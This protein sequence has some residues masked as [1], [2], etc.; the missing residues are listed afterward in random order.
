MGYNES[1]ILNSEITKY[2]ENNVTLFKSE[3]KEKVDMRGIT[4]L[5][6]ILIILTFGIHFSWTSAQV[7]LNQLKQLNSG[8]EP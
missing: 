1:D 7:N 5:F 8:S 2:S 3:L 4:I 6:G